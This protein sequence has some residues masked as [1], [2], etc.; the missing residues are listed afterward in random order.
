LKKLAADQSSSHCR[1]SCHY[2]SSTVCLRRY[3]GCRAG[4]SRRSVPRLKPVGSGAYIVT[5]PRPSTRLC[6]TSRRHCCQPVALIDARTT[7]PPI[8]ST[9]RLTFSFLNVCSLTKKSMIC[10]SY[11]VIAISMSCASLKRGTTPTLSLF[12]V[13]ALP[14]TKWSIVH[15]RDPELDMDWIHPWIGLD[16]IGSGLWGNFVDW[17]GS[18]ECNPLFFSFIYFLY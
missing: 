5:V 9:S 16:W 3:R 10:S 15:A 1:L 13:W 2:L 6:P 12:D 8:A 7:S 4:R 14:V 11:D 18:D 17:I